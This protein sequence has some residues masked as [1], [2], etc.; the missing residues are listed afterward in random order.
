[1][2]FNRPG[3]FPPWP[4]VEVSEFIL[5]GGVG[6]ILSVEQMSYFPIQW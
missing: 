1:M 4:E 6:E 5:D 2:F 3:R